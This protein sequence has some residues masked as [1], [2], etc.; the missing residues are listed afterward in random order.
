MYT[1]IYIIVDYLGSE[2]KLVISKLLFNQE[3]YSEAL[4]AQPRRYRS[5]LSNLQNELSL[6]LGRRRIFQGGPFQ[7]KEPIIENAGG[8]L[9][10]VV[11]RGTNIWP[12]TVERRTRRP[13]RPDTGLQ[14]SRRSKQEHYLEGRHIRIS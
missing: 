6:L 5:V 13:V 7:V 4:P 1:C 2:I 14:S 8:C 10:A 11:A 12:V 3:I 9:V